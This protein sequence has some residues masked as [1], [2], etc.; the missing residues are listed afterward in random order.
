MTGEQYLQTAL[1]IEPDNP[2][3]HYNFGVL[4]YEARA[5]DRAEAAWKRA[6]A[7]NDS[8]ADAHHNLTYLLYSR[9]EYH[10]A[11]K[12]CQ[13]ALALGAAVAPELVNE[14]HRR[15]EVPDGSFEQRD[16]P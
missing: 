1:T 13:K 10:E 6:I 5:E 2:T 4:Y 3:T 8:L 7:L 16:T 15:L 9:K 12:Y 11:W 14:I